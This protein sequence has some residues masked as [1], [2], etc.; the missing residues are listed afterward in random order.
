MVGC[1][2]PSSPAGG[3]LCGG[4]AP[5]TDEV[6]K[7]EA[8]EDLWDTRS[9]SVSSDLV[10]WYPLR[11]DAPWE[12]ATS[13]RKAKALP[14]MWPSLALGQDRCRWSCPSTQHTGLDATLAP[15][16]THPPGAAPSRELE[17]SHSSFIAS[18]AYYQ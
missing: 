2:E 13:V 18:L 17:A 11:R 14:L 8:G 5:L 4:G 1:D 10:P 16:P 3:H 15:Q 6:P 12:A 7:V 9:G